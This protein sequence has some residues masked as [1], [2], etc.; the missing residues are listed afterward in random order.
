MPRIKRQKYKQEKAAAMCAVKKRK[1]LTIASPDSAIT[2][3]NENELV[4]EKDQ[5]TVKVKHQK[6]QNEIHKLQL[7]SRE[8]TNYRAKDLRN[9][10][11]NW[12]SLNTLI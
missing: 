3:T 6:L 4:I 1:L 10:L 9:R 8:Q 2:S 11:I 5:L 7:T 12:D